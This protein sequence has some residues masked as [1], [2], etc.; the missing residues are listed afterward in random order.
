M[1]YKHFTQYCFLYVSYSEKN[2]DLLCI[3]PLICVFR[4][5]KLIKNLQYSRMFNIYMLV[6]IIKRQN[7]VIPILPYWYQK[8]KIE[9][10]RYSYVA[11]FSKIIKM[12]II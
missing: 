1:K 12:K 11:K 4:P 3:K 2:T 7:L 8:V 6:K 9:H 10:P 5:Q